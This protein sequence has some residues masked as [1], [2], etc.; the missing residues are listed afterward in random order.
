M[1]DNFVRPLVEKLS[2][3]VPGEQIIVPGLIRLNTNENPY[4]PAPEVLDTVRHAVDG[5][6]SRY[7]NPGCDT[8]RA[9]LAK[10]HG[11]K[12]ENI[13]VGVGSDEV[14]EFAVRTFV[15]PE[16][17]NVVPSRSTV[18]FFDPS[19]SLY[20]VL[21]ESAGTRINAVPLADGFRLPDV[22]TLE[23]GGRWDFNAALTF[24]T[25]PNAPT[26]RGY[27]TSDLES[28]CVRQNGVVILDEAY[29][30]FAKENA[31]ELALKMP[32]VLVARTFSKAY[33]LCFQ[34]VGYIVGPEHLISSM[35]KIRGSYNINGLGQVAAESTLDHLDYYR[36]NF[37]RIKATRAKICQWLNAH[38]FE[39]EESCTN[40]LFARPTF[41]KAEDLFRELHS[42]NVLV[43]WWKMENV[44]DYLRI[45][46]GTEEEMQGF[47]KHV[48][49]IT[50]KLKNKQ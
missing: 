21:A 14:L 7:P 26:G 24:I 18:Q 31:M 19:Y 42:R 41:M 45:T 38:G 20:P 15:E 34:R 8:L 13:L 48:S 50:A 5:R 29:A 27:K 16:G 1:K 40:F 35:H 32:N 44:R 33:C 30:D 49:E 47:C 4:P 43:R 17:K 11:C 39:C 10:L 12:V 46:I 25:T 37:E 6:L 9:K 36:A 3:Y 22:A 23:K 2:P 28:L